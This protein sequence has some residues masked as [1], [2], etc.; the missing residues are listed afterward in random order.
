MSL[1][2]DELYRE[3][4]AFKSQDRPS[5]IKKMLHPVSGHEEV[6]RNKYICLAAEGKVVLHVGASGR[7]HRELLLHATKVYGLDLYPDSPDVTTFDLDQPDTNLPLFDGVELIVCGEILEH[8]TNPGSLIKRLRAAYPSQPLLVSVPNAFSKAAAHHIQ[9]GFEN[10]NKD[11]V[12]WYSPKT[13]EWL[14][15]RHGYKIKNWAWYNGQPYTA[16]GILAVA[17]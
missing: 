1:S 2:Y 3:V 9:R 4:T 17:E 11:H 7:L 5:Y 14:L 6:D 8:L 15:A 16:E 12:A 10:V 13:L